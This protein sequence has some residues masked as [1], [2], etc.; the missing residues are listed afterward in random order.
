MQSIWYLINTQKCLSFPHS[1]GFQRQHSNE[2]PLYFSLGLT[3]MVLVGE[4]FGYFNCK[5]VS[6]FRKSSTCQYSRNVLQRQLYH[7]GEIFVKIYSLYEYCKNN[8]FQKINRKQVSLLSVFWAGMLFL[9]RN[10]WTGMFFCRLESSL[11]GLLYTL[12]FGGNMLFTTC[13]LPILLF[14]LGVKLQPSPPL[15]SEVWLMDG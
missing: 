5:T 12:M 10:H 11:Q 2:T 3:V 15:G 14:L 1:Q 13:K 7:K 4:I 6:N 8:T 9:I